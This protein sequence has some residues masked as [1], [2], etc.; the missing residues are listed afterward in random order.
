MGCFALWPTPY[1]DEN[2]APVILQRSREE[3]TTHTVDGVND[4]F[5]VVAEDPDLDVEAGD[6][7]Q[8]IWQAGPYLVDPREEREETEG[9][10]IYFYSLI[11][12][13]YDPELDGELLSVSVYDAEGA[14]A[15]SSWPLEVL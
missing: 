1:L 7:L 12:I 13:P 9:E 14:E 3:G 8:F 11:E 6:S 2:E 4:L 15:R 5:F 10:A